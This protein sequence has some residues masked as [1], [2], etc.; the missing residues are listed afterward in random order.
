MRWLQEVRGVSQRRACALLGQPRSTQ[1]QR[2]S[3]PPGG[4]E[5]LVERLPELVRQRPRF[6]YRRIWAL[7]RREG[8]RV[9]RKKVYLTCPFL[10]GRFPHE[11]APALDG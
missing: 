8:W 2:P 1:R 6:G 7:L 3:P 4:E 5:R 9:N 10:R 11:A